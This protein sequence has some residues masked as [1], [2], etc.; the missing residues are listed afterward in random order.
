MYRDTRGYMILK[1]KLLQYWGKTY[2]HEKFIKGYT[3]KQW[4]RDCRELS[5]F[6]IKRLPI[7]FAYDNN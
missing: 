5:A 1:I 7:R 2:I 3:E 4:G 6:I